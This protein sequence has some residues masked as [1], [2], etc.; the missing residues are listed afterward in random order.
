M[1]ATVIEVD[2]KRIESLLLRLSEEVT[3]IRTEL[4]GFR[5]EFNQFRNA[6]IAEFDQLRSD[7]RAEF[8]LVHARIDFTNARVLR[9]EEQA[10]LTNARLQELERHAGLTNARLLRVED[11]LFGSEGNGDLR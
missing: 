1:P 8:E 3:S 9:L 4:A 2:S 7:M 6:T 11:R 10:E 5:S